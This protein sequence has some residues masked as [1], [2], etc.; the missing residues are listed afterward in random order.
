MKHFTPFAFSIALASG[1]V[2]ISTNAIAG[3]FS[4]IFGEQ[5]WVLDGVSV[6]QDPTNGS[7]NTSGNLWGI[8]SVK[9]ISLDPSGLGLYDDTVWSRG[10]TNNEY[11]TILFGNID[12][13]YVGAPSSTGYAITDGDATGFTYVGITEFSRNLYF[14]SDDG[15]DNVVGNVDT[16][17]NGQAYAQV[18]GTQSFN[19]YGTT[20][21][22]GIG[23]GSG[24]LGTFG[25]AATTHATST[26]LL[27]LEFSAGGIYTD[28]IRS[29]PFFASAGSTVDDVFRAVVGS[30]TRNETLGYLDVVG[31]SQAAIYDNNGYYNNNAI[32]PDGSTT[33]FDVRFEASNSSNSPNPLNATLAGLGWTAVIESSSVTTSTV[34]EPSIIAL[35]GMGIFGFGALSRRRSVRA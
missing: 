23:L 21:N 28:E 17:A 15:V 18:W 6:F 11:R 19:P 16:T 35:L 9:D 30:T 34:P 8:A 25:T 27:D 1:T 7:G 26:L 32:R 13:R 33:G 31:G 4:L 2:L 12:L 10:L 3:P 5:K 22:A 24:A 29:S 20:V 14:T